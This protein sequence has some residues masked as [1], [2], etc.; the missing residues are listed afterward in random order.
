MVQPIPVR[1]IHPDTFHFAEPRK[2]CAYWT[3]GMH[4]VSVDGICR[5]GKRFM[6]TEV[7]G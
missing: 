6:L 2:P 3:N 1:V 7:E 4:I 5:C